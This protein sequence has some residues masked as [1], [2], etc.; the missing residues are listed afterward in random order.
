[1]AT[2]LKIE[3]EWTT[4]ASINEKNGTI[5]IVEILL[6]ADSTGSMAEPIKYGKKIIDAIVSYLAG[7]VDSGQFQTL[8]VVIHVIGM[9]DWKS[10]QTRTPPVKLFLNEK[11]SIE[12]K[13]AVGYSF[14]LDPADSKAWLGHLEFVANAITKM[15]FGTHT[16]GHSGGD[17]REEYG[18][19]LH[20]CKTIVEQSKERNNGKVVKYFLLA[21]TDDAQ[22]G[23]SNEPGGDHWCNGVTCDAVFG[24]AGKYAYEYACAYAPDTHELG[25]SAWQP[26][27]AYQNIRALLALD[28]TIV[29][30]AI[31]NSAEPFYANLYSSWLG[32]LAAIFNDSTGVLIS[33]QKEDS[34]KNVPGTVVHLLNTLITSASIS[35]ELDA[36][37]KREL[38]I[39]KTESLMNAAKAHSVRTDG[40]LQHVSTTI[41]AAADDLSKLVIDSRLGF[42]QQQALLGRA[43]L[44]TKDANVRRNV[45]NALAAV[46]SGE[47][48]N[49]MVVAYRSL[50]G[51]TSLAERPALELEPP[52]KYRMVGLGCAASDDVDA[53]DV[54]ADDVDAPAYRSLSCAAAVPSVEEP[55]L[56]ASCA[57]SSFDRLLN[58]ATKG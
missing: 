5:D 26:H 12:Q 55:I 17:A 24:T 11:E 48:D 10:A 31:G 21:I 28:V 47:A 30:A 4:V 29:W 13:R 50:S 1:M 8:E 58:M 46:D 19:G 35:D 43:P 32:T 45:A 40:P 37:K 7:I 2:T 53:D 34:N 39:T 41:E 44:E 49:A 20:F 6:A 57:I 25:F 23:T 38:A 22:H 36:E 52:K 27:S 9:N 42:N 54:D 33:W 14:V 56:M 15:A 18:T 3:D 16:S 51:T